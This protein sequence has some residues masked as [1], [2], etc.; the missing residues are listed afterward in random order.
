MKAGP[1]CEACLR[2]L[3]RQVADLAT[4]D[5]ELRNRIENEISRIMS[6]FS[7]NVVPPDLSNEF[8]RANRAI[9]KNPDPFR[10]QKLVELEKAR[11][12]FSRIKVGE[13]LRSAVEVAAVGNS[14]DFFI[15]PNSLDRE[16]LRRPKFGID[17]IPE[18]EKKIDR[19]DDVLYLADNAAEVFFD[20]PFLKFLNQKTRVGYVVKEAPVQNDLSIG[21]IQQAGIELPVEVLTAPPVVGFYPHLVSQALRKRFQRADLVVAKGMG[22]YETLTELPQEGRFF[23]VIKAKCAPVARNLGISLGDYVALLQ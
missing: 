17:H 15:D 22:N 6:R 9:S 16:F 18:L 4:S 1:E 11:Q 23:Y 19:A 14:V 8:H 7:T 21:D 13:D 2:K 5:P 12:A 3:M 10:E 20:I